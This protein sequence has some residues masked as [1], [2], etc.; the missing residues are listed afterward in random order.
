[1]RIGGDSELGKLGKL[2]KARRL[3][4]SGSVDGRDRVAST[5]LLER[6]GAVH[7]L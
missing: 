7:R 4:G 5:L 6:I 3:W 2:G 1:M